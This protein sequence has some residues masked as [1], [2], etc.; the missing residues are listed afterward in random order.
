MMDSI[1]NFMETCPLLSEIDIN[2]NYLGESIVS[3]S[4]DNVSTEPVIQTYVDGGT[5]R[6]YLFAVTLRQNFGQAVSQNSNAIQMLEG[7][8]N[9]I[10]QQNSV[11]ILPVL[12]GNCTPV[13]LEIYK[14]G[15]LDDKAENTA[16]YQLQCRLVYYHE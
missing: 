14:T 6:Q 15:W 9:W 10:E 13:S 7:I 12:G 3:C 5:L 1:K 8:A 11:G 16:R 2:I 4:V